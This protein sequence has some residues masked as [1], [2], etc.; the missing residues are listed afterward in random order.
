[1][2]GNKDQDSLLHLLEGLHEDQIFYKY[3]GSLGSASAYPLVGGPG[4]VSP[5][6]HRLFDSVSLVV[7]SMILQACL[8]LA[9]SP[10]PQDSQRFS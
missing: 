2:A 1:M 9:P 7:L 4:S 3:V 10:L 6:G 5:H 8:L